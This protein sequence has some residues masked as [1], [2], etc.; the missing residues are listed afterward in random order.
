QSIEKTGT[1]VWARAKAQRKS[2]ERRRTSRWSRMVRPRTGAGGRGKLHP[3]MARGRG[4]WTAISG[5]A[6]PRSG[7][8]DDRV[9]VR[10]VERR[11]GAEVPAVPVPDLVVHQSGPAQV[12]GDADLEVPGDRVAVLAVSAQ[13]VALVEALHLAVQA[14]QPVAELR[15]AGDRPRP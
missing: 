8:P 10:E 6:R 2:G 14:L 1:P 12:A 11:G 3:G 7:R 13:E 4:R 5:K 15:A 9:G